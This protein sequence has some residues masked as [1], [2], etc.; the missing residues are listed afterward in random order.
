MRSGGWCVELLQAEVTA[1]FDDV[2]QLRRAVHAEPEVG[3]HL[4]LTQQKVLEALR[5]LDLDVR[6]GTRASSIIATMHGRAGGRCV[7]L[8]ADMDALEIVEQSGVPFS[9]TFERR[10]HACGHDAHLAMLVGAARVLAPRRAEF[11]GSVVFFFEAGEEGCHGAQ[12]ALEEGLIQEGS[13]PTAALAL[14]VAPSLPTGTIATRPGTMMASAAVL[15]FTVRGRGAHAAFPHR[16]VD[17]VPAACQVVTALQAL[18]SREV[19]VACPAVLSVTSLETSSCVGNVIPDEVRATATLRTFSEAD[20]DRLLARASEI[21]RGISRAMGA[22]SDI[23][24]IPVYPLTSNNGEVARLVLDVAGRLAGH[25][26][27]AVVELAMPWATSEDF[28]Y[29]LQSV[30]GAVALL[31]VGTPGEEEMELH[32]PR[33]RLDENALRTGI[34][35]HAAF[36]LEVLGQ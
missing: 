6:V 13:Y 36:A 9:S 23:E 35:L 3:L 28:G 11:D 30:P 4:P 32:S 29:V 26:D 7:L 8:R 10:M 15:R 22:H 17:P 21:V 27:K 24:V 14:H 20:A 2:V 12:V 19:D 33:L 31:G 34:A 25:R 18:I 16:S 1:I 5:P